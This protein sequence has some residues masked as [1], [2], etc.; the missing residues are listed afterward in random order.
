MKM[1]GNQLLLHGMEIQMVADQ[2]VKC[3]ENTACSGN[4]VTVVTTD[5]GPAGAKS[6]WYCIGAMAKSDQADNLRNVGRLQ[7][8]Y[9]R[10]ACN[11]DVTIAF[12]V[13]VG[14]TLPISLWQLNMKMGVAT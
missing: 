5:S 4:P 3:T 2:M 11:F 1:N 6:E 13:D 10:V 8:Q 9:T 14:S 7:V 12:K